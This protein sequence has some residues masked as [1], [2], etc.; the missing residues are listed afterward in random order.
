MRV[1][2]TWGTQAAHTS[3]TPTTQH[4][5]EPQPVHAA[6]SAAASFY[7]IVEKDIE[8][9][10]VSFARFRDKVVYGLNVASRCSSTPGEYTRLREIGRQHADNPGLQMV[11]FPSGQY[12]NQEC[13][14]DE[15][16]AAFVRK[17]GP[18]NML[19]MSKGNVKGKAPRPTYAYLR[20]HAVGR[21][22]TTW[23]FRAKFLVGRDGVAY[24]TSDPETA[25]PHLL[26]EQ[27]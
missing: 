5:A 8:G 4:A 18:P 6:M 24:G 23:N 17:H 25:I 22:D 15:E 16:I 12:A 19:V 11:A 3:K 21:L 27:A 20:E 1:A 9:N 13:Q 7:D 26:Q 2:A 14:R 10:D